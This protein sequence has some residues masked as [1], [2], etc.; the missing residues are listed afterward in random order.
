M[1]GRDDLI[2]A[3]HAA[4]K[5]ELSAGLRELG[6]VCP[7]EFSDT[8]SAELARLRDRR[9]RVSVIGQVK[10]GKSTFL[11]TLIGRPGLLPAEVNP[12]TTVVTNLHFGHPDEPVEGGVFHFFGETDWNRMING[13]EEARQVAEELLPGFKSEVLKKQ[14][15]MMRARARKRLGRFYDV[16][17]GREHRYDVITRSILNRYV[18]ASPDAG[19]DEADMTGRYSDITERAD[20]YMP[21]EPFAV[22]LILSDTPGVNDPFLVRDELTCRSLAES[23]AFV[24]VL[25]AHQALTDVDVALMRMLSHHSGKGIL[26]F[27]NRIDE[28][29]DLRT[30]AMRI[31]QDVK[32]RLAEEIP[33]R[34]IAVAAGSAY[35]G[36]LIFAEKSDP[37]LIERIATDP[38]IDGLITGYFGSSE[39]EPTERLRIASGIPLVASEL[40]KMIS[41]G[42]GAEHLQVSADAAVSTAEVALSTL[43]QRRTQISGLLEASEDGTAVI[44]DMKESVSGQI[45][46][47]NRA[48]R[49]L[50]ELFGEARENFN[51][52]VQ[53]SWASIRRELDL[54]I[55]QFIESQSGELQDVIRSTDGGKT[56][57]LQTATLRKELTE[58]TVESYAAARTRLD[59]AISKVLERARGLIL[60]LLGK[61]GISLDLASLPG[62]E[63]SPVLPSRATVLTVEL[64]GKRGWK[65]WQNTALSPQDAVKSLKRIIRAEIFPAVEHLATLSHQEMAKRVGAAIEQLESRAGTAARS[66]REHA[67]TLRR[68]SEGADGADPQQLAM[69]RDKL[70]SEAK[71]IDRRIA[72]IARATERIRNA[73]TTQSL[74][75]AA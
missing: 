73:T 53:D 64:T 33:D 35:W 68:E 48:A 26:V 1:L 34:D 23:D 17:M 31:I 63:V 74:E 9:I 54:V 72:M 22:P 55:V 19:E 10:A 38:E 66:I 46:T 58:R 24:V 50:N 40:S 70:S 51:A 49:D 69:L 60:P 57:E 16:I 75:G 44:R 41:H 15:E 39:T 6:E 4:A 42:V 7:P 36:E 59:S 11:S 65:F 3:E 27:I 25:S 13:D 45:Q 62:G 37:G 12:W 61:H 47:A 52:V 14:V 30:D 28:V 43:R 8:F 67:E 71:D 32:E 21:A 5:A 20:V 56:F 18:C 29:S 2:G